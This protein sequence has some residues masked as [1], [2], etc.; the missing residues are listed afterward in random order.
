MVDASSILLFNVDDGTFGYVAG[1]GSTTKQIM[2]TRVR[3]GQGYAGS[4][5]I[6]CKTRIIPDNAGVG[7]EI[8][9]S[10]LFRAEDFK[11]YAGC[12]SCP[13]A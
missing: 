3:L 12:L 9:R 11:A 13:K 2:Q 1:L 4:I 8:G 5:A 7:S 10:T 6:D